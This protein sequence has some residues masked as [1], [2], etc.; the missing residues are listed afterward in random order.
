[1]NQQEVN[2]EVARATGES[3]ETVSA[4]GFSVLSLP[5]PW[6]PVDRRVHIG[7][8]FRRRMQRRRQ[9]RRKMAAS[10]K[11]RNCVIIPFASIQNPTF[12][13]WGA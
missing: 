4:M 12:D 9:A 7:G 6:M 13:K 11:A 5:P 10:S 1:M 3:M 2:Q 8:M